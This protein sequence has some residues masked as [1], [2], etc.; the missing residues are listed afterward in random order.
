M[1]L[2]A[3]YIEHFI[4]NL[5]PLAGFFGVYL[6]QDLVFN[7]DNKGDKWLFWLMLLTGVGLNWLVKLRAT[8]AMY[9]L[10]P[11][12]MTLDS[13]LYPSVTYLLQWRE[14]RY[15]YYYYFP[16]FTPAFDA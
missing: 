7:E 15:R 6:L 8:F 2:T 5:N 13:Q 16:E 9:W 4:S 3:G 11:K 1:G 10:S 12:A 14:H